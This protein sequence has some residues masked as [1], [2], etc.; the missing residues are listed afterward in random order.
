MPVSEL[1]DVV[2]YTVFDNLQILIGEP[3][4]KILKSVE[5]ISL[6]LSIRL[7]LD[8]VGENNDKIIFFQF[9]AVTDRIVNGRDAYGKVLGNAVETNDPFI[10]N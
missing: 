4:E 3:A 10:T 2:K 7:F 9:D 6:A 8:T 1:S 5:S